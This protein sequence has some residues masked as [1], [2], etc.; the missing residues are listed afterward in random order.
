VH[1][2]PANATSPPRLGHAPRLEDDDRHH[3]ANAHDQLHQSLAM[4]PSAPSAIPIQVAPPPVWVT[5]FADFSSKYG[6]A[7]RM[8]TGHTGVHYNDSTK[9]IWEPISNKVEYFARI[10]ETVNGVVHATDD[11]TSF[12]MDTSPDSLNKKVTL[13]K[14]F[15]TYLSRSRGRREG[16][17]VVACSPFTPQTSSLLTEPHMTSDM[18]YVKRW[19]ITQQAVIFRLSNKCIQVCFFDKHEV[20]LMSEQKTVAF[21]DASGRR[22]TMPLSAVSSQSEDVAQRLKYTK[23]ILCKLISNKEI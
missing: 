18:V 21:T 10:K 6:M 19:M 17:E 2:A 20:I 11:L 12:N 23:D 15:K 22:R 1:N 3:L 9:M 7:Y 16:V 5:E 14:Y 13:I 4:P 8:S